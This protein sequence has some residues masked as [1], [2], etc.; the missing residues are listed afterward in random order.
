M[1]PRFFQYGEIFTNL[2]YLEILTS[3]NP[4]TGRDLGILI[5]PLPVFM[6]EE[7]DLEKPSDLPKVT[8]LENRTARTS[9]L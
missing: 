6:V 1:D 5:Q 7:I 8:Q 2:V 9:A 4:E 3:K